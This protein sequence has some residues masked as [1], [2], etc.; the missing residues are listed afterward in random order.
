MTRLFFISVRIAVLAP[1]SAARAQDPLRITL[2]S[3]AD[4][5]TWNAV[6]SADDAQ[7]TSARPVAIEYSDW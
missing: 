7:P 6:E 3:A 2:P 5:I 1:A 4:D